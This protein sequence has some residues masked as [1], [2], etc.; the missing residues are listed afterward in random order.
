MNGKSF[1]NHPTY[2]ELLPPRRVCPTADTS[3]DAPQVPQAA[4]IATDLATATPQRLRLLLYDGA[5]RLCREA[6]VALDDG[7]AKLAADRLRRAMRTVHELRDRVRGDGDCPQRDRFAELYEQVHRR[8][9]EADFYRRREAVSE[10]ISLLSLRR[11]D[12]G[13][14]ARALNQNGA[15]PGRPRPKS[16]V[17]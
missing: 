4:Y 10:T 16:W 8:L 13:E 17:G 1:D 5:I 2:G 14:F 15:E 7:D 12:W 9:I 6:L 3:A 11:L